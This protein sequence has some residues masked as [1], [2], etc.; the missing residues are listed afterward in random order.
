MEEIVDLQ[1]K[2]IRERLEERGVMIEL[3]EAARK[4]L[5]REGF[6]SAFGARPL[7]RTLQ[8]YVES[9]LSKRIL[10]GEFGAGD[11][12]LAEV[13]QL[14]DDGKG[15]V[16]TKQEPIPVELPVSVEELGSSEA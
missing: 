12:V 13:A 4:W 6:D 10:R 15:L 11:S 8:R 7:R 16:F 9:P 5:A 14:E 2:E 3:T 1:M